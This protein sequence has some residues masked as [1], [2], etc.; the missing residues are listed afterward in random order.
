MIEENYQ[1]LIKRA[2][3]LNKS[4][5]INQITSVDWSYVKNVASGAK[6]VL[7]PE[8]SAPELRASSFRR[9]TPFSAK[10]T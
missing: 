9:N 4:P 10:H 8:L 2:E 3:G 6:G 7:N 5:H 1:A